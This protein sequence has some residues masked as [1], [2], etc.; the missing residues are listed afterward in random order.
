M[1]DSRIIR[2]KIWFATRNSGFSAQKFPGGNNYTTQ[3]SE[4]MV[5]DGGVKVK[6]CLHFRF[7]SKYL[8]LSHNV[9]NINLFIHQCVHSWRC[10]C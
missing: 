6:Y 8:Q 4:L 1:L 5:L 9:M 7:V 10:A 2:I 3:S